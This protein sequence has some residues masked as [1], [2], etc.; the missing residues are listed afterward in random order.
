MQTRDIVINSQLYIQARSLGAN[1]LRSRLRCHEYWRNEGNRIWIFCSCSTPN[2]NGLSDSV[3]AVMHDL[4][5]YICNCWEREK[6]MGGYDGAGNVRT[7]EYPSHW[8][9]NLLYTVWQKGVTNAAKSSS[10][11]MSFFRIMQRIYMIFTASPN[12]THILVRRAQL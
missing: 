3:L 9:C 7:C 11:A 6:I 10:K 2:G 1:V 4:G 12:R 8:L 5:L